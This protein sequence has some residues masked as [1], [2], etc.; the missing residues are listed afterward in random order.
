MVPT[1]GIPWASE[2]SEQDKEQNTKITIVI[3]TPK[4]EE[5]ES[6]LSQTRWVK[7]P[8]NVNETNINLG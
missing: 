5:N 1:I 8:Y 2:A 7:T 4:S 3:H 6:F